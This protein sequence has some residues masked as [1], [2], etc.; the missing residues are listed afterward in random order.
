VCKRTQLPNATRA[1]DHQVAHAL[2]THSGR[3]QRANTQQEVIMAQSPIDAAKALVNGYN[4]KNWNA[5]KAACAPNL[6]YDE[7]ATH[8]KTQGT[9]EFVTA[10]QGWAMA[11]PDSKATFQ[12]ASASG[13]TVVLEVTWSGT[14]QGPLALSG[15]PVAP[16]HKSFEM[17]ACLVFEIVDGKTQ[18][19]RQYFDMATFLQ[20]LGLGA[21]V[22][23]A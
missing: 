7:V 6:V 14:H 1:Y 9:A 23:A 5:I 3:G 18:S 20:Q 22:A 21:S 17:R 10:W 19:L 12:N 11:L 4:E 13:N 2:D 16:T 8:R 15:G